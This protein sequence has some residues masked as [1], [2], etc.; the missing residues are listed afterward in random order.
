MLPDAK[1]CKQCGW[2]VSH[3]GPPTTDPGDRKARIGVAAGL[4]VAYVVLWSL[5]QSAPA[6]DLSS[7]PRR[8]A[9]MVAEQVAPPVAEPPVSLGTL[10]VVVAST[11]AAATAPTALISIKIADVKSASIPSRDALQYAFELPES[12]QKCKL[13][14]STKGVGGFGRN[15]EVFLLTDDEYVFWHANPA[16]IAQSSWETFRGSENTLGYDLHGPGTYHFIVS[17]EMSGTPQTM[18]VKAQVKCVR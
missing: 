15:I 7:E 1:E 8:P 17:N 14:G 6:E 18:A 9:P 2:D 3:D 11:P 13:V 12:D 10:P 4:V 16:A 5:V